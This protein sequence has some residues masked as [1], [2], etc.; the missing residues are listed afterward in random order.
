M[1]W[2]WRNCFADQLST[3]SPASS[4]SCSQGRCAKYCNA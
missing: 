3:S 2:K 1:C 4:V